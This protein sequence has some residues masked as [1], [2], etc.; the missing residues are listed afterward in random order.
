M[1]WYHRKLNL[2]YDPSVF[3]DIID[4][5]KATEWKDGY[6]QNGLEWNG[7]RW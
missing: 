6:D 1:N 5:A 7:M 3:N 4:Y 2:Q